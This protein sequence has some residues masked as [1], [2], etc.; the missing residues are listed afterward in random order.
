MS[1]SGI[2][3]A[4]RESDWDRWYVEHLRIM[5]SV[6]GVSS[7][8]RFKTSTEGYSPSLSMYSIASADVFKDPYYLSVRGM[9]EWLTL[10]D[11]Q[12]YRRN[13][14]AGLDNAPDVG[15]TDVLIVA[16]R[17]QPDA[18]VDSIPWIWLQCVGIDRS[19]NYRG[20]AVVPL[21]IADKVRNLNVAVYRPV[22]R[23]YKG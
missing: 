9:G 15:E 13:L 1:Q 16:D 5:A 8:Q 3:D 10:I 7:A 6:P 11:K 12:Y 4:S 22:T 18:V 23:S 14:F 19:T 20:V 21:E 2:T 17:E